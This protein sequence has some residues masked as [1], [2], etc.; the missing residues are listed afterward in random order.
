MEFDLF[1]LHDVVAEA[2]LESMDKGLYQKI[3]VLESADVLPYQ[4]NI[5]RGSK[6][7]GVIHGKESYSFKTKE[8][9]LEKYYKTI[10][11]MEQQGFQQLQIG[12]TKNIR[13]LLHLL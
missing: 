11:S 9:A 8:K 7:S 6:S 4:V 12:L 10:H 1:S 2:Y 5:E 13:I 3:E